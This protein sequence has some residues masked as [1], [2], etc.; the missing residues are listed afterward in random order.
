MIKY[1]PDFA[2]KTYRSGIYNTI[3]RNIHSNRQARE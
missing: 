1:L 2:G 3:L